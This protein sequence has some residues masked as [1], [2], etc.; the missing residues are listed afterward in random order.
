MPLDQ[1]EKWKNDGKLDE[2]ITFIR[3]SASGLATQGEIS[4]HLGITQKCFVDMKKRHPDISQ[5]L[6]DGKMDLKTDLISDMVKLAH[7]YEEITETQD[8]TESGKSREQ[9][10]KVNRVKKMIG[11]NYKAIIYL[12]TK[13]FGNEYSDKYAELELMER[14]LRLQK[15]EWSNGTT[16]RNCDEEN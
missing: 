11:P 5:A 13:N 9:K 2:V 16:H 7:G 1:Y 6:L 15:E 8:V 14:R 4:K 12:L 10:K 3:K